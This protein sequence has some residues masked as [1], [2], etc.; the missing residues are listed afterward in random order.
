MSNTTEKVC[1]TMDE[2]VAAYEEFFKSDDNVLIVIGSGGSGKSAAFQKITRRGMT[3]L[4][5]SDSDVCTCSAIGLTHTDDDAV[6]RDRMIYHLYPQDEELAQALKK[7]YN[8]RIV[9]FQKKEYVDF[10]GAIEMFYVC[11]RDD[12]EQRTKNRLEVDEIRRSIELLLKELDE[13]PRLSS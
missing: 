9:R 13:A 5:S 6:S 12:R 4:L 10:M 7:K 2:K 1:S 8:A 3:L 11:F